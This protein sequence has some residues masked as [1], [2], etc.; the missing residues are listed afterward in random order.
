V[1]NLVSLRLAELLNQLSKQG[2]HLDAPE[3]SNGST[4]G[5]LWLENL[6]QRFEKLVLVETEA[7]LQCPE[8]RTVSQCHA[9]LVKFLRVIRCKNN[10]VT[11]VAG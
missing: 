11:D 4:D 2:V 6:I 1:S 3:L 10:Q 7:K 5:G 9:P 8:L